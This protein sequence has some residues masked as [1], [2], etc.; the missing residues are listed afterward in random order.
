MPYDVKWI[1][2]PLKGYTSTYQYIQDR[3]GR[4]FKLL[5]CVI[6]TFNTIIYAGIG[7]YYAYN[8]PLTQVVYEVII[9]WGF[10]SVI[11][12]PALA[13]REV[14][15]V[16]MDAA[17]LTMG[18]VCCVV[19]ILSWYLLIQSYSLKNSFSILLWVVLKQLF[20]LMSSNIL[21]CMRDFPL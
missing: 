4:P 2:K 19:S 10:I 20:G 17:I 15:N 21:R 5:L 12:A 18:L 1:P 8:Y 13:I 3:F 6:Y 7:N 16:N 11:Y 9:V 14:C